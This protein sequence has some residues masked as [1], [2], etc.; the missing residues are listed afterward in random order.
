[1][2]ERKLREVFSRV[3]QETAEVTGL[4]EGVLRAFVTLP[5]DS[6]KNRRKA[7]K[8]SGFKHWKGVSGAS[9]IIFYADSYEKPWD[10]FCI[11][12]W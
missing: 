1:M 4:R 5:F 12:F 10:Y 9:F 7:G 2:S 8:V 6:D 11:D 3:G